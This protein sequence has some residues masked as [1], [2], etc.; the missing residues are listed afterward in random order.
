MYPQQFNTVSDTSKGSLIICD[1][2][3]PLAPLEEPEEG[4]KFEPNASIDDQCCIFV[5]SDD[6]FSDEHSL[7]ESYVME[8]SE[9]TSPMELIDPIQVESSL[10]LALSPPISLPSSLLIFYLSSDPP[11]STFVEYE[12]FMLG[13]H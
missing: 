10:N 7:E 13:S 1:S 11:N 12:S 8:L 6:I 9:V 2:P 3:V 4:D 5:E